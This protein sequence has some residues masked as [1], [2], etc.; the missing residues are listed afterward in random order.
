[1][2]RLFQPTLGDHELA[3]VRE[4]FR[5][6]W[7]GPGQR[8]RAFEKAFAEY[9]GVP[10]QQLIAITSCTEGL[11][12]AVAALDAES[13][14]EIILPSISFIGAAHAVR[15]AGARVRLVDVDAHTLNP[16]PEA[17]S[18]AITDKTKAIIVLH[19]GGRLERAPE[20]AALAKERGVILI[21]DSAC[22]LGGHHNGLSYGSFGDIAV[23]SFDAMKLLCTGDGGMMRVEDAALRQKIY[24][25]T[26]LGGAMAGRD[27][28]ARSERWWEVD[29]IDWG[30]L[31]FM[32]DLVASIGLA[33]LQR[34]DGFITARRRIARIYD[35]Q[36]RSI[37]WLRRPPPVSEQG[38]PYFYWIQTARG[39]RDPLAAHLLSRD[40]YTSFRYWPLH[41]TTL[42]SDGCE[43]PGA[44]AAAD[45][46]L[47]L[48]VHQNLSDSDVNEIVAAIY[49]FR[50]SHQKIT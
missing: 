3:A 4:V 33:Q 35:E 27:A 23:W 17:V 11:F 44:D 15:A 32:N 48:P 34:V 42:Y 8:V 43:Y 5:D 40:I 2:I 25:R 50:P 31:A 14:E 39:L 13:D 9:V 29:P 30:R 45:T 10:P 37:S 36:L 24:N 46:T 6:Q 1:M 16:S 19:F 12:Q 26:H 18:A 7:P 49:D 21:E 28:V 38:V 22:A 20:I 41:R 47:L